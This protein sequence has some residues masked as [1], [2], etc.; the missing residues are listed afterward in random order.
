MERESKQERREQKQ[1]E[2]RRERVTLNEQE[3]FD[4]VPELSREERKRQNERLAD[5]E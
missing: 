2:K 3:G 1:R 4:P 5:G